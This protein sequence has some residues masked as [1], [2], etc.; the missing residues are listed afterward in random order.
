[1]KELGI[2][3]AM[4]LGL[5]G[6]S[7][8]NRFVNKELANQEV[9]FESFSSDYNR[10]GPPFRPYNSP[11]NPEIPKRM[12]AKYDDQGR[13]M[14][15]ISYRPKKWEVLWRQELKFEGDKVIEVSMYNASGIQ[16]QNFKIDL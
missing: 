8:E 13:M 4:I 14:T 12:L 7:K 15:L 9:Y 10:K 6:C 3:V 1:M 11:K 2:L 16:T 5:L